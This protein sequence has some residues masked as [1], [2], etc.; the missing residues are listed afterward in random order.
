[1]IASII[2]KY[3]IIYHIGSKVMHNY[4]NHWTIRIIAFLI[5]AVITV[6]ITFKYGLSIKLV[7]DLHIQLGKKH[8]RSLNKLKKNVRPLSFKTTTPRRNHICK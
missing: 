7:K 3:Y 1:M 6:F 5:F 4:F 2:L 8:C